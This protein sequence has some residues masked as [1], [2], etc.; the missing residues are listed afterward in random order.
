MPTEINPDEFFTIDNPQGRFILSMTA[1][2]V[3]LTM[4]RDS[5]PA[6]KLVFG[7]LAD[8]RMVKQD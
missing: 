5:H 8:P 2:K 6:S 1:A 3:F 7:E 4:S